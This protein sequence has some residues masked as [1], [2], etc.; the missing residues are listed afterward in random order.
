MDAQ[1]SLVAYIALGSNVGDREHFLLSAL[2]QLD[3]HQ[4]IRVSGR[5]AIYETDPV[6]VI[7]QAAFLNMVLQVE[8]SLS[9]QELFSFMLQTES[10]LGRT[11]ELRWGPRT[12]D[13]DLLLYDDLKQDNPQLILPHP[14]MHERAFVLVPLV[15]VM[16]QRLAGQADIWSVQLE[17]LNGKE[18]VK[19]WKKT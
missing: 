1:P 7:D 8:T 18:G 4:R 10:E 6:G 3:E 19:Q 12:I 13:L 5:S 9:A 11:R 16:R 2:Q 15:D 14:R 17:K